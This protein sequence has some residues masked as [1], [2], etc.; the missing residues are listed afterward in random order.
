MTP[1]HTNGAEPQTTETATHKLVS[2]GM[3]YK[4]Q[5]VLD[6][7][8]WRVVNALHDLD[9]LQIKSDPWNKTHFIYVPREREALEYE[10]LNV[11]AHAFMAERHHLLC[12]PYFS[13]GTK[14]KDV[15]RLGPAVRIA[16]EWL[17]ESL[18]AE[19]CPIQFNGILLQVIDPD[20]QYC[21]SKG[22]EDEPLD[23]PMWY[24]LRS[25]MGRLYQGRNIPEHCRKAVA[26]FLA[27]EPAGASVE[28]MR[29][30][31]NGLAALYCGL[32]VEEIEED[33]FDVWRIKQNNSGDKK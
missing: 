16:S 23:E 9:C 31:I 28:T 33:G 19:W 27:A 13:K 24:A 20:D 25:R 21:L 4:I 12:T 3:G 17:A 10:Y 22:C 2:C 7:L 5:D 11:L 26:V 32:R 14:R 8:D 6:K 15:E 30:L 1:D 18:I 29:D